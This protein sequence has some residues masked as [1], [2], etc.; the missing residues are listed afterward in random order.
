MNLFV[1][2]HR[3]AIII[4]V[5]VIRLS[6]LLFYRAETPQMCRY[7]YLFSLS[8]TTHRC[9]IIPFQIY[10][11]VSLP[12]PRSNPQTSRNMSG[13]TSKRHRR[14]PPR[15]RL[16]A[17]GILHRRIHVISR[18]TSANVEFVRQNRLVELGS[19]SFSRRDLV[20]FHGF[21]L[22]P[23]FRKTQGESNEGR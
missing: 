16:V 7:I 9:S 2:N 21:P 15:E 20:N 13:N 17:L 10:Y 4:N 1:E 11:A 14:E 5:R 3:R 6:A 19:S 23:F 12:V 18:H 8:F 22:C